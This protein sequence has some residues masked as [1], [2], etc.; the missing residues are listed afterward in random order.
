MMTSYHLY[1]YLYDDSDLYV[2]V[3][4]QAYTVCIAAYLSEG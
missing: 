3:I 4:V 2:I 1:L